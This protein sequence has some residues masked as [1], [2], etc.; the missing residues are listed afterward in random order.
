MYKEDILCLRGNYNHNKK[1]G[2]IMEGIKIAFSK[3]DT[4]M[5][6]ILKSAFG[7]NIQI[8]EKNL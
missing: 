8:Y 5:I 6:E 4:E 2:I 7:N 3:N 1:G